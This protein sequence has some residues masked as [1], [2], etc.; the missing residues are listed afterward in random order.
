MSDAFEYIVSRVLDNTMM[1]YQKQKKI[2]KMIFTKA[3][4]WLIMRYY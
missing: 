3:G 2:P 1:K 4:K